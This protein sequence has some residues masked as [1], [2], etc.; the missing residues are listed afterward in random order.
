MRKMR[1]GDNTLLDELKKVISTERWWEF[2]ESRFTDL[3]QDAILL[4][5][6]TANVHLVP[7]IRRLYEHG[8]KMGIGENSRFSLGECIRD[9]A[10]SRR[11]FIQG[12]LPFIIL[13]PDRKLVSKATI[14]IVSES[15]SVDGRVWAF[16]ELEGLFQRRNIKCPGAVLGALICMGDAQ[17]IDFANNIIQFV[18]IDDWTD[19]CVTQTTTLHHLSI[20]FWIRLALEKAQSRDDFSEKIL[21]ACATALITMLHFS[22]SGEVV[23]QKRFFPAHDYEEPIVILTKWPLAEYKKLIWKDMEAILESERHPKVFHDVLEVWG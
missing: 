17:T 9:L 23:H 11:C 12:F 8:L 1:P 6:T 3:L 14:D 10:A 20:Q 15:P 16:Q 21:C 2:E 5:A 7:V 4:Y 19:A 22:D 18:E 13:D